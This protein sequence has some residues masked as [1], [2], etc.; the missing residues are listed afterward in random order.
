MINITDKH[1]CCGCEACAQRCPKQCI[2]MHVDYEGFLYPEVDL[3][4]CI[5]CGLCEKVCPELNILPEKQPLVVFG[6]KLKDKSIV[7][8]SSSGGVFTYLADKILDEGGVVFGA[9]FDEEWNVIHD[10]TETKEGLEA[11]RKSKYVQS[12]IGN[13]FKIAEDFL[14]QGR[15]VLFTGTPCQIKA[16]KLYLRK[17]YENLFVVDVVCHGCPSPLTWNMYLNYFT[18]ENNISRNN[19]VNIDFRYKKKQDWRNYNF[20]IE[21][22]QDDNLY[23]KSF[24]HWDNIYMQAFL[25]NLSLRPSCEHCCAK[26]GQSKSDL[27]IADFWGIDV[28]NNV[29]YDKTGVSLIIANSQKGLDYIRT[30]SIE[31]IETSLD[32]CVKYNGGLKPTLIVHKNRDKYFRSLYKTK[33]FISVTNKYLRPSYSQKIINKLKQ[34]YKSLFR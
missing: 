25:S 6:A 2:S 11:F 14:K 21:Y 18:N 27:S 10:F 23:E 16:L 34:I 8:K 19:I 4:V 29:F 20:K 24:Y 12:R 9:R 26:C 17:E 7:L 31:F 5:D 33:D 30:D 28:L 1:K 3:S 22:A 32:N 13:T 15:K